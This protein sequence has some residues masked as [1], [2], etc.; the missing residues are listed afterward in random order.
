MEIFKRIIAFLFP[1]IF[2]SSNILAN[3]KLELGLEAYNENSIELGDYFISSYLAEGNMT[4][5]LYQRILALKAPTSFISGHYSDEF[6]DNF[7]FESWSQW[8]DTGNNSMEHKVRMLSYEAIEDK[9]KQYAVVWAKPQIRTWS[10]IGGRENIQN[11]VIAGMKEAVIVFG[12]LNK[13]NNFFEP[14]NRETISDTI[15]HLYEPRFADVDFDSVDELLIRYNLSKGDGYTQEMRIYKHG[16]TNDFCSASLFKTFAGDNGYADFM[17]DTIKT[18]N[19]MPK[20]NEGW[21]ASSQHE[22]ITYTIENKTAKVLLT[23]K[24]PN[25]NW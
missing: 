15:Q 10:I 23:R 25:I 2:F 17:I 1:L 5:E 13:E 20:G 12:K 7:Q 16:D 9:T 14:C 18:A 21:L 4:D 6:L 24:I 19:Q 3:E 11:I 8:Q 22:I